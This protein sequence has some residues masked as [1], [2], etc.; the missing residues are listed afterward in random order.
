M[1]KM[2][3]NNTA[4]FAYM[5]VILPEFKTKIIIKEEENEKKR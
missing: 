2:R 4:H 3:G 5:R 1:S